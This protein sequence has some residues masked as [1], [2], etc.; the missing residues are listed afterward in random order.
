MVY[1]KMLMMGF[2]ENL[3]SDRAIAKRCGD[4]MSV[5]GFLG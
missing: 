3:P 1:L 4:S 5:R 2:F